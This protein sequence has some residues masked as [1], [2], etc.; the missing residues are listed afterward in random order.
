M[1]PHCYTVSARAAFAVI[2][3]C[4]SGA[5]RKRQCNLNNIPATHNYAYP[6]LPELHHIPLHFH[7]SA[8]QYTRHRMPRTGHAYMERTVKCRVV[9]APS[10]PHEARASPSRVK[11]DTDERCVRCTSCFRVSTRPVR[12]TLLPP[13]LCSCLP[14]PYVGAYTRRCHLFIPHVRSALS[15]V[16]NTR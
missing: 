4:H 13:R 1:P 7:A 14:H 12:D 8:S 2:R 10:P 6:L 11:H 3:S 5:R 9:Y 15:I 16:Q